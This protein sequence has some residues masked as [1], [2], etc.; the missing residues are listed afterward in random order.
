MPTI[1]VPTFLQS[2]TIIVFNIGD[3]SHAPV[4]SE[5]FILY[6]NPEIHHIWKPQLL[7]NASVCFV[8]KIKILFIQE[9]RRKDWRVEWKV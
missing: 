6:S 7:H 2:D 1:M 5:I 3:R 4:E 9:V 8:E